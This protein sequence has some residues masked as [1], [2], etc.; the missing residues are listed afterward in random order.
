MQLDRLI[1][2]SLPESMFPLIFAIV[3]QPLLSMTFLANREVL[4]V[5]IEEG[6]VEVED[7]VVEVVEV[8]EWI[9]S[10][11]ETTLDQVVEVDLV[12]LVVVLVVVEAMEDLVLPVLEVVAPR[13]GVSVPLKEPVRA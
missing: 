9:G 11:G 13:D 6:L 4:V 1:T 12:V 8:V 2:V 7:L 10:V 3:K 5:G